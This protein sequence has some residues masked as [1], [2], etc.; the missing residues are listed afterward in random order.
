MLIRELKMIVRWIRGATHTLIVE[1]IS[2]NP[3]TLY[4]V[5]VIDSR[6]ETDAVLHQ[7]LITL[8]HTTLMII[9]IDLCIK[10]EM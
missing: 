1:K 8:D 2:L 10:P 5:M 4:K 7:G 6:K 3:A 9:E